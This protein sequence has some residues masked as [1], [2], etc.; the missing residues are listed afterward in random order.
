MSRHV[1]CACGWKLPVMLLVVEAPAGTDAA[2]LDGFRLLA[3]VNCPQ[4]PKVYSRNEPLR[5]LATV[6][7]EAVAPG[8]TPS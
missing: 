1:Q 5:D 6:L 8:E 3:T 4:C 2:S 7:A